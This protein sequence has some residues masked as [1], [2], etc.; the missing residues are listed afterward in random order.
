VVPV[1]EVAGDLNYGVGNIDFP[2]DVVVKGD[3]R[4]GFTINAGGAV[5][6]RGLVE[7]ATIT[8]GHDLAVLGVVGERGST[9]E[10]GG[11][12]AA[13]Y[14]HSTNARVAGTA[15]VAR[16]IVNCQ[17]IANRIATSST[18]R[19]V[20]GSVI[21]QTDIDAGALGGAN[22]ILTEVSVLSRDPSA[23]IRARRSAHP[24][25][26]LRIGGI[27]RQLEDELEAASFWDV[28]GTIVSL[29]AGADEDEVRKLRESPSS[30][31]SSGAS[32]DASSTESP[33][34]AA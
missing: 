11:D 21:A 8:A 25:A 13:Q 2:G 3:V 29:P 17:L 15:T 32:S 33:P 19:I 5:A 20:G 31:A 14:L 26:V 27:R 16:E 34:T 9:F 22:G 23:V 30:G 12:L 10:V 7:G 1:Y 4:P 18:G 28:E 6:V 24:G